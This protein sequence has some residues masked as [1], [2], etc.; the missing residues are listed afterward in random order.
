VSGWEVGLAGEFAADDAA[1]D[2]SANGC[3]SAIVASGGAVADGSAYDGTD[4]RACRPVVVAVVATT[5]VAAVGSGAVAGGFV[6]VVVFVIA[7]VFIYDSGF[8]IHD[9]RLPID[10]GGAFDNDDSGG[11]GV[12]AAAMMVA[13]A[14]VTVMGQSAGTDGEAEKKRRDEIPEFH[15]YSLRVRQEEQKR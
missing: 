9:S 12:I 3:A 13:G 7:T 10:D 6:I 11:G 2:G 15:D 1:Q 4:D 14:V 5:A 8:P